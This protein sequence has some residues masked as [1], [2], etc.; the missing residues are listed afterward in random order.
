MLRI[1]ICE[2]DP[3][4]LKGIEKIV[5]KQ[6][7][8]NNYSMELAL[9]VGGPT[10]VLDYLDAHPNNNGLY[11]L[12]VDL[13][14]ELNGI[15]L[16]A[17]IRELDVFAT[18]VFITTHEELAYLTFQY[19]VEAME[20]IVK[21]NTPEYI[22][23]KVAECMQVAYQRYLDGKSSQ[24]KYFTVET[25]DQCIN[26]PYNDILFFETHS[27]VRHKVILH[28]ESGKIEFRGFINDIAKIDPMFQLCH[29]SFV[30]NTQKIKSIDKVSRE[31]KLTNGDA[32]VI[33]R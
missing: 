31:L 17:K 10:D 23:S 7:V 8:E 11:F 15:E 12:D 19:K 18:I 27:I 20:Y 16:G 1:F 14:H 32:I 4:Q 6:I 25:S 21:D 26:I 24:G 2:D 13:G 30:V 9:S 22:R 3:A 28:M 29:K 33:A 5:N